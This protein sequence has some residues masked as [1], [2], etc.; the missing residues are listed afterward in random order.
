MPDTFT[1]LSLGEFTRLSLPAKQAYL[2][3]LQRRVQEPAGPTHLG[4]KPKVL[5]PAEYEKLTTDEKIEYILQR[6]EYLKSTAQRTGI[7]L[8]IAPDKPRSS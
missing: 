5:T 3:D 6:V 7:S 2:E 8:R 1:L 4:A